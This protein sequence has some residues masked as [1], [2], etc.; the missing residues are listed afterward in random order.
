[1]L[2]LFTYLQKVFPD[3]NIGGRGAVIF[4]KGGLAEK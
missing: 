1:M 2:I 4:L 3:V